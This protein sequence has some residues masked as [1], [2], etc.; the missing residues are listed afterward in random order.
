MEAD[1]DVEVGGGAP[2]IDALWAGFVDLRRQPERIEEIAEAGKFPALAPLLRRLNSPGSPVWTAKCDLW[3]P[4]EPGG[5]AEDDLP[6]ALA[7]YVD[8][9]PCAGGVFPQWQQAEAFCREW[10]ARLASIELPHFCVELVVRQA[11]AGAVEGFGVTAYLSAE[12]QDRPGAAET[13]ARALGVF[14]DAIPVTEHTE[15]AAST[16]Q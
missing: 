10:V 14:A 4:V 3:E 9:L 1:W 2:V 13:L 15:R 6:A 11:F 12:G 16:L 7:V 8:L 5:V